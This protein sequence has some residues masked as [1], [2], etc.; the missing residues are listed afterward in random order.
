MT[1]LLPRLQWCD[2]SEDCL[3]RLSRAFGQANV[4]TVEK[5]A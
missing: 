1:F 2:G 4:K 3:A 5:K